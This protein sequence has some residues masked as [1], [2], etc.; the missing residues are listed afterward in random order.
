MGYSGG[1]MD[2]CESR[3]L[4]HGVLAVGVTPDYWVIKNSWGTS[5]GESGY[6]RVSRGT[7]QCL[8]KNSPCT[9]VV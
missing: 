3:Q 2:N 9:P 6:I 7:N 1:V 5:W 8:L 4:D